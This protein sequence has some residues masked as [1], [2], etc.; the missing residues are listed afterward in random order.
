[1]EADQGKKKRAEKA[2]TGNA[3]NDDDQLKKQDV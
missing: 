2:H 3:A 1:M